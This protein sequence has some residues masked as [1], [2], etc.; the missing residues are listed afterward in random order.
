MGR[1][2]ADRREQNDNKS[3]VIAFCLGLFVVGWSLGCQNVNKP[4][5]ASTPILSGASPE[6]QSNQLQNKDDADRE[7][8]ALAKDFATSDDRKQ[9]LAWK[10]LNSYSR[11]DLV[12][13]L[14]QLQEPGIKD[15]TDKVAIAFVLCNLDFSYDANKQVIVT[16][17]TKEPHSKNSQSDWEAG[18]IGRLIRRGDKNLLP[19]LFGVAEWSAGALSE[20]LAGI[21]LDNWRSDPK[22]SLLGLKSVPMTARRRVYSLLVNDELLTADDSSKMKTYL[23]SAS[24]DSNIGSIAEEMLSAIPQLEKQREQNT[25]Q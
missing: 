8:I 21:Y 3:V 4:D 18:L 19:V 22:G 16:A 25:K 6:T 11:S 20:E 5:A 15:E 10:K 2:L 9:D 13:R 12:N 23:R 14:S 1:S 24:H 17:L 7:L